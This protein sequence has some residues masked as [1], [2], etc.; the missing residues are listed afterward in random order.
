MIQVPQQALSCP[1]SKGLYLEAVRM[2]AGLDLNQPPPEATW[3]QW[4]RS[5]CRRGWRELVGGSE[6]SFT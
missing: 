5:S 6:L 2:A 4:Q 3:S 1:G